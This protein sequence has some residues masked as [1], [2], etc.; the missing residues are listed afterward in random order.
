MHAALWIRGGHAEAKP[1]AI[2]GVA[3]R[4]EHSD[5]S[6]IHQCAAERAWRRFVLK[7][8]T[9][10]CMAKCRMKRGERQAAGFCKF[11]YPRKIWSVTELAQTYEDG[12]PVNLM[13]PTGEDR[14]E[15][16]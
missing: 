11:G 16:R 13:L 9:H 3:P 5:A 2:C 4:D 1:N 14:Y 8:Q 15:Y 12:S 6:G 10:E 7:V